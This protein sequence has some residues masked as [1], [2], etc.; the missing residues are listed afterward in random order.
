MRCY[1]S[2]KSGSEA[3]FSLVEVLASLALI[4]LALLPIYGLNVRSLQLAARL[5]RA[6]VEAEAWR[7]A[8]TVIDVANP[9]LHCSG[10][11]ELGNVRLSWQCRLAA[12]PTVNALPPSAPELAS[13]LQAGLSIEEARAPRAGPFALGI[14]TVTVSLDIE[15]RRVSRD[16]TK[17]GWRRNQ[18]YARPLSTG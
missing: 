9:A 1:V 18:P 6:E 17:L 3:G 5:E 7:T 12:E 4:G 2:R 14:Y 13:L 10:E 11:Q 15:G 8:L 16:I